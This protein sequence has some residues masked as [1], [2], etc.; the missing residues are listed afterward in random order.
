MLDTTPDTSHL[1]Q[2]LVVLRYVTP[3]CVVR[4][5]LVDMWRPTLGPNVAAITCDIQR[6]WAILEK[7]FKI[8]SDIRRCWVSLLGDI[9]QYQAIVYGYEQGIQVT[10][11]R[12]LC[13]V[14]MCNIG[15]YYNQV[16]N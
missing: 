2:P 10:K 4:E 15:R 13:Q 14:I 6:Y 12:L 7:I 3:F 11:Q 8:H 16:Q 9:G 5:G 1:D